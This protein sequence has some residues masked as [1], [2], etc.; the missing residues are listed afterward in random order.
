DAE[1][2]EAAQTLGASQIQRALS[3]ILPALAP[4]V[5]TGFSLAFARAVGEYGSGIFIAGNMPVKSGIAP[6]LV[7]I[8]LEQ[9]DYARAAS[10]G[11]AMLGL[12][13]VALVIVNLLQLA[14]ARRGQ[15]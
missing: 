9:D 7:V 11:L 6:L 5:I 1:I 15:R 12:S 8:K 14:I 2:E 13:F 3:V 4:A 10:V